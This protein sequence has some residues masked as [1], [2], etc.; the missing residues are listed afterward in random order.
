MRLPL[1]GFCLLALATLAVAQEKPRVFITDTKSWE[2]RGNAGGARPQTA[3]VIKTFNEKCSQ[4]TINNKEEKADYV[5][6]VDHEGGK[7]WYKKDNKVAVF[8]DNGDSIVS[9]STRSL[10]G[11]VETACEVITKDW[12]AGGQARAAARQQGGGAQPAAKA[13]ESVAG[14]K[15][16]ISSDPAGADIEVDGNFMG[17]TPSS[18]ELPAGEHTIRI[19]KSGYKTWERKMR[20]T[21][22]EVKLNAELEKM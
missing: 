17:S 18:I 11:S 8:N 1:L 13:A 16:D 21:G 2:V 7:G 14:A 20:T 22:G 19:Q 3:E 6:L 15:L 9:K 10:G 5:V 4:V 12:A